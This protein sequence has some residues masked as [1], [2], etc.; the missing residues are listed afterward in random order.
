M[1]LAF[2]R[3]QQLISPGL[4]IGAFTYSQGLEW[5]V[6]CGWVTNDGQLYDWLYDCLHDSLAVLELPVLKR[7]RDACDRDDRIAFGYWSDFLVASRETRELRLE[8]T[9]RARALTAVLEKL[10]DSAAMTLGDWQ[11]ALQRT[12]LAPLALACHH[13]SVSEL[14]MLRGHAWSWLEGLVTVAVKLVP[15]GQSDGQCVLYRLSSEL[16]EVVSRAQQCMDDELGASTLA[17]AIASSLHETQYCR[18]FRS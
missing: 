3:L 14:D 12:Q 17:A 11:P 7:L 5:A 18:L 13:W 16:D 10:P 1:N 2:Y 4:P 6:E 9:Q 8:E 15:L